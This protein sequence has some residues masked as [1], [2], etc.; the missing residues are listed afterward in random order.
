M[1]FQETLEKVQKLGKTKL[2]RKE[3]KAIFEYVEEELIQTNWAIPEPEIRDEIEDMVIAY[4]IAAYYR[5][6]TPTSGDSNE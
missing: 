1:T 3:R 6:P 2:T 5:T 4:A